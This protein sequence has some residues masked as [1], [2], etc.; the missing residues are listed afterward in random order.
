MF[1]RRL[2]RW[3]VIIVP[4]L[5]AILLIVPPSKQLKGGIDLV[6]GSSLLFEIDT[7]GMDEF[8]RR[9]LAEKVM[10]ILKS[11][12]DPNSQMNLVWRPIGNNKIEIQMP[13]PSKEARER[14]QAYEEARSAIRDMNV[15]R[16]ELEAALNAPEAERA[17]RLDELVHGVST[18]KALFESLLAARAA[19]AAADESADPAAIDRARNEYEAA[20][21]AALARSVN[22]GQISDVLALADTKARAAELEKIKVRAPEYAASIDDLVARYDA[23]VSQ[24]GALEDPQDLKRRIRGAGVLEFRILAD[25]DL[26]SPTMTAHPSRS[27]LREPIQKYVEQLQSRGPRPKSGDKYM[28]LPIKDIDDFLSLKRTPGRKIEDFDQF[29]DSLPQIVEK[30]IGNY[31]VLV[32]AEPNFGLLRSMEGAAKWELRGA[33]ADRSPETGKPW[34]RFQLSPKGGALFGNLTQANVGRQLAIVLDGACMSHATIRSQ[35]REHGTIEG[36]F[37]WDDV[38]DLVNTLEAGSLPARLKE[39]PL[40]EKDIGPSLGETNRRHGMRAA[41]WA[42]IVV[43]LFMIAYYRVAGVV[44]DV[45]LVLN[46]LFTLAIM[47]GLEATFTLP[48]IAGLILTIGMAVDANV[49]IFERIREERERGV[50]LRKAI[51]LGYERAFSAILD[52]NVTSLIT[53]VILYTLG[54]EEIKGFAMTLGFGLATSMFTA[55]FVTRQIFDVLTHYKIV[56][57]LKMFKF[58]SRI[59]VDWMRLRNVFMTCSV[60]GV[61]LSIAFFT[62]LSLQDKQAVYDIDFLGGTSVLVELRPDV[63]MSDEAVSTAITGSAS[64]SGVS[65][66]R[67]A[68]DQLASA[69]VTPGAVSHR[70]TV[71]ADGLSGSEI[72]TLVRAAA[73]D[74]LARGGVTA[75]GPTATFDL[76]P[77]EKPDD[78]APDMKSILTRA[79]DY[80]R[81]AASRL[82][83][84]RV[85]TVTDIGDDLKEHKSFEIVTVET[86]KELVQEAVVE[87]LGDKL[88]IER[89]VEFHVVTDPARAP[90]GLFPIEEDDVYLSDVIGGDANFRIERFKGGVVLVFDQVTPP[91][92]GAEIDAR[93]K[94]VRLQPE[95]QGTE[96][97]EYELIPL[98]TAGRTPDGKADLLSRMALVTV[99]EAMPYYDNPTMWEER[100]ARPELAQARLAF[101][102]ERALRKVIQFAPQVA[103]QTQTQAFVSMVL[104]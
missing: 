92:S 63:Q 29:K 33:F 38:S 35:I 39:T 47:A 16:I 77:P 74:A 62:T 27:D 28:W 59:N 85:Q 84:A 11:R 43:G 82:E 56:T 46:L 102:E 26:G 15:S 69:Q 17:A 3:L 53:C 97:R 57:E 79:A 68:A 75:T 54:S 20:L 86:N 6:G 25:R 45:A 81:K 50:A 34:V 100:V 9:G 36:D 95:F 18:R 31:Y 101:S 14:R 76:K 55:L 5:L 2:V 94:N 60:I 96:W 73:E 103:A 104:A 87:A 19:L 13:K 49:L 98:A 22:L 71:T 52:S 48:G 99:D 70:F 23:W 83:S 72:A 88:Q 1:E 67:R 90:D 64:G 93:L 65:F 7:A 80:T 21:E 4:T 58:F 61:G 37:T 66:L 51:K 12:V 30:Y 32:H 8:Q 44:A 91:L 42:M 89:A 24:K 78:P 41:M 40:A 10:G